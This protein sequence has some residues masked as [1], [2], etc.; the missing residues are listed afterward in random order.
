MKSS[1][2]IA[3]FD[4]STTERAATVALPPET[5]SDEAFYRFE[6]DAVWGHDWFC[7]G[8][9]ADIPGPGDYYTVTVGKDPLI[10]VRQQ[11]L[12]VRVLANVCQHRGQLM[13]EEAGN[14][15]RIRCPMHSW[16]YDLGGALV[17]A[18][19]FSKEAR[20][21]KS[22]VCLPQLRCEVWEGFLFATY[23]ENIT[24]VAQRLA[25]LSEQLA[26]YDLATLRAAS[27]L[28]LEQ[29][30]WNWKHYAD[31]C[32]HCPS[33]HSQ[34]WV[35]MYP[36]PASTIDEDAIYNDATN[37][38]I[39]YD[40][41]SPF[42]DA[43]PTRT[44]RI[45]HPVLPKLTVAQRSRLAY[46]TVAPNLLIVAMPDKVKYFLWLPAGATFSR[47]GVSWLLPQSTH[48]DPEFEARWKQEV[49]ELYPV[50]IEDYAGWRRYQTGLESR[51][52]PRGRLS[53]QE[54]VIARFQ[55]WLIA[56]YRAAAARAPA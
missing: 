24:P 51:F 42:V 8:R 3:A 25:R 10:A 33:L 5:F 35:R 50:M 28:K 37:G 46:I 56:K 32:Y 41:V 14:V 16:T 17:S 6:L 49:E 38:I 19:G 52:A 18:P 11:D 39:A 1:V 12:S 55:D 21:D 27:P 26:N 7:L 48:D 13:V 40:L 34:S 30:P 44:G 29:N 47:L 4:S 36:M 45:A 43:S 23:D 22:K 2:P 15:R 9:A 53:D 31:E 20:F 54:R